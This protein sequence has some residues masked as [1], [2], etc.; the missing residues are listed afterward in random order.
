MKWVVWVLV[1]VL[2]A[3]TASHFRQTAILEHQLQLSR[4]QTASLEK[5]NQK[6]KKQISRHVQSI[7]KLKKEIHTLKNS[8]Q[9]QFERAIKILQ[10]GKRDLAL[11]SL[12]N[13]VQRHP[14]S[15]YLAKA[16]TEV[17][18]LETQIY[19]EHQARVKKQQEA[20]RRAAEQAR[21]AAMQKQG[22]EV[23]SVHTDWIRSGTNQYTPRIQLQVK[24]LT[25]KPIN[26]LMF[27]A[28]FLLEGTG[29]RLGTSDVK[30]ELAGTQEVLLMSSNSIVLETGEVSKLP[31]TSVQVT[32][33]G[34][35]QSG[36]V[37]AFPI[38]PVVAR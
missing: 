14:R 36:E 35:G 1:L 16:S 2:A 27:R 6:L 13:F 11:Q 26:G 15:K 23:V 38:K 4:Q 22:F 25:S 3:G 18:R 19:R 12:R 9:A 31:A 17:K 8:D 29:E 21:Q 33:D 10:S 28:K 37:G 34:T 32:F 24:S 5:G 7:Q 20:T 30:L